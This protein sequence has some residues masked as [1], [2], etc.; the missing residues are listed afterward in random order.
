MAQIDHYDIH[1][2]IKVNIIKIWFFDVHLLGRA[3]IAWSNKHLY[4]FSDDH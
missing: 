1:V 3:K 4:N 2:L